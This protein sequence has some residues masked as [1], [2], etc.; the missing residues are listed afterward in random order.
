M[1]EYERQILET[2]RHFDRM[3]KEIKTVDPETEYLVVPGSHLH[4]KIHNHITEGI[5]EG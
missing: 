3:M 4:R 2:Q 1:S 5:D